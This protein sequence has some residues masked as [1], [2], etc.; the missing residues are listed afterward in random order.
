LTQLSVLTP[1]Y[2]Y[3]RYIGDAIASVEAQQVPFEYEHVVQDNL[4]GDET[5]EVVRRLESRRLQLQSASDSGQSDALNRAL[6]ASGGDTV[7]WLNADEFYLPGAVQ[8]AQDFLDSHPSIGLVYGDCAFVDGDGTFLRLLPA[9]RPSRFVLRHYGC[10]I[11]S[12][13]V[14]MRRRILVEHEPWNV[15]LRQ[16]M[17]WDLWLRLIDSTS[18]AYIPRV[19]SAFRIHPDQVTTNSRAE[20]FD[21]EE[22]RELQDRHRI[23]RS[24]WKTAAARLVHRGYKL[25]DGGYRRQKQA[26]SVAASARLSGWWE[27]PGTDLNAAYKLVE[28]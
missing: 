21:T 19:M 8:A 25:V 9:H 26:T 18:F 17:D 5:L 22:V 23:R 4:S 7:A 27:Q 15:D 3:G 1:S 24:Q 14:F 6:S 16:A 12:C 2:N 28:V 20:A 11:P 13:A 10:F